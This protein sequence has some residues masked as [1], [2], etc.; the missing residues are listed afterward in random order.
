MQTYVQ[1]L[2]GVQGLFISSEHVARE[3]FSAYLAGQD[4]NRHFPGVH[5]VGYMPLVGGGQREEHEAI[6]RRGGFRDYHI[7]PAG[8][9]PWYAPIVYLEPFNDSNR[10]AFGFDSASE[11]RRHATLEQARDSGQPA[12][13]AR[14]RLVQENGEVK[15]VHVA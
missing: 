2:Y 14:I 8:E 6:V 13:S 11:P 12:M 15:N 5:G 7:F 9:R 1:V 3:E 10:R 4:L